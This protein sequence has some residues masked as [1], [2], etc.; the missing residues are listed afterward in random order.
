MFSF[1]RT[2]AHI[3]RLCKSSSLVVMAAAS[4]PCVL[5]WSYRLLPLYLRLF[6][7]LLA[8]TCNDFH[9][10]P[11][12][13]GL[14]QSVPA[15]LG[16]AVDYFDQ[17]LGRSWFS[18][19]GALEPA[20]YYI[21]QLEGGLDRLVDPF[22][23]GWRM[24]QLGST[25]A[26]QDP[27]CQAQW[28]TDRP[29][30]LLQYGRWFVCFTRALGHHLQQIW[31]EPR[32]ASPPDSASLDSVEPGVVGLDRPHYLTTFLSRLLLGY[33]ALVVWTTLTMVRVL[34]PYW[35]PWL[36]F[37]TLQGLV[38]LP[39]WPGTPYPSDTC[40][41]I[42]DVPV[43]PQRCAASTSEASL[44]S[45]CTFV[46]SGTFCQRIPVSP[47]PAV[48][49]FQSTLPLRK[50]VHMDILFRRIRA[51]I[52]SGAMVLSTVVAYRLVSGL[53]SWL[54]GRFVGLGRRLAWLALLAV[55]IAFYVEYNNLHRPWLALFE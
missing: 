14:C 43:A 11:T 18:A 35:L 2:F 49:F 52:Q 16:R 55:A 42:R 20:P 51:G 23:V 45:W 7:E 38:C 10:P 27:E 12:A 22:T 28:P 47:E 3:P 32:P 8:S 6:T 37:Q 4:F 1:V 13:S 25:R 26:R 40:R 21:Q 5:P 31:Q 48:D 39:L 54:W 33:L 53:S 34:Q 44:P 9:L 19:H 24:V 30:P 41:A 46:G 15:G 17:P 29:S 50:A 36:A